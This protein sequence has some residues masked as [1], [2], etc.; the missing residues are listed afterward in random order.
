M[1]R[2]TTLAVLSAL[3]TLCFA[4]HS[5]A[6]VL[7]HGDRGAQVVQVQKYLIARG[8]LD[9]N[10]DGVYGEATVEAIKLFQASVG[11]SADG[12]CGDQTFGLLSATGDSQSSEQSDGYAIKLGSSGDD[13]A[14]VQNILIAMGYLT[15]DAD[16]MCGSS[17]VAAIK[18]FQSGAGLT[19]DGVAGERTLDA[20]A[21]AAQHFESDRSAP[22]E[23]IQGGM[24][25]VEEMMFDDV[26]TGDAVPTPDE[27]SMA[28]FSEENS[29]SNEEVS[30]PTAVYAGVGSVIKS[31]M[32]G[33]GVTDVQKKLIAQGFLSGHADGVCGAMTVEA[34][35]NFQA[36]V[37]LPADGVCG[38]MTY[39]ALEDA[40]YAPTDKTWEDVMDYE[41]GYGYGRSIYV[42]ATAYS[43]YDPGNGWYTARGTLLRRGII[44]VDPDVIPLGTRVYI[45]GYG[46]AIADDTGG[47]IVG[48]RI[49]IA[50]DSHEEAIWFGRQQL[51]I[52]I[53]E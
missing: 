18:K 5:Q 28:R 44:A 14:E 26:L 17:T 31:G 27:P 34:I 37:G 38:L 25:L 49:D 40:S 53:I 46:E 33:D 7:K 10:A 39:A 42:D 22:I 6:A 16:G 19:A 13:V 51:E 24:P 30:T 23:I 9:G 3:G 35:K 20:L 21:D 43:A 36:S 15:G 1:R 2:L 8:L 50:F 47:A 12:E 45:P 48:N 32:Y 41:R 11:L 29:R 4:P 52:Y